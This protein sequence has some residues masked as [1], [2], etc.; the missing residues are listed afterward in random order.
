MNSIKLVEGKSEFEVYISA[1]TAGKMDKAQQLLAGQKAKGDKEAV[2]GYTAPD[3][4]VKEIVQLFELSPD[5]VKEDTKSFGVLLPTLLKLEN[6]E[7]TKEQ[8]TEK[9]VAVLKSTITL[10][11]R[12]QN[13]RI[14]R[15][16]VR[17]MCLESELTDGQK[18][19][20]KSDID[21]EFWENQDAELLRDTGENFR[22]YVMEYTS[23]N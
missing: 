21:S 4:R 18:K 19:L 8:V 20:I 1:W 16:L 14:L 12:I 7:L 15:E 13:G 9:L 2:A 5:V 17:L 6:G 11:D 22:S 10:E 23:R 3:H